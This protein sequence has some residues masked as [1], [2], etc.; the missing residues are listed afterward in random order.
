MVKHID[1]NRPSVAGAGF[2]ILLTIRPQLSGD[3]NCCAFKLLCKKKTQRLSA[4]PKMIASRSAI[5]LH[6]PGISY[7]DKKRTKQARHKS[8]DHGHRKKLN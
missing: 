4:T 8:D 2:S 6:A 7:V 3:S 1:I 5:D